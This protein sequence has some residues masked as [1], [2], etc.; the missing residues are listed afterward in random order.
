MGGLPVPDEFPNFCQ[1]L[2]A[3]FQQTRLAPRTSTSD[4]VYA[5]IS[6]SKMVLGLL[7]V[8]EHVIL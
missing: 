7:L 6:A 4:G 3:Q 8:G 5:T 1:R 2:F